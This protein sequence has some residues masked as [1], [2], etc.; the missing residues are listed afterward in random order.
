[1]IKRNYGI[2]FPRL[3]ITLFY[4]G[5]NEKGYQYKTALVKRQGAVPPSMYFE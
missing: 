4:L 3:G 5:E 2:I 1:M